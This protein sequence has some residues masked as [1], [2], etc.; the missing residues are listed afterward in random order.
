MALTPLS[1][2]SP[3]SPI[4]PI[5]TSAEADENDVAASSSGDPQTSTSRAETPR[6]LHPK[7]RRQTDSIHEILEELKSIETKIPAFIL[8]IHEQYA[9]LVA[10]G[11][12]ER[13]RELKQKI[14]ALSLEFVS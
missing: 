6:T 9:E 3:L 13:A 8:T 12:N 2:P 5:S 11:D 7:K 4:S 10:K 1:E 14:M